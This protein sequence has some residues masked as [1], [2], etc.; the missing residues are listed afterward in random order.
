MVVLW[1]PAPLAEDHPEAESAHSLTLAAEQKC[2][3]LV[4]Q[5]ELVHQRHSRCAGMG[6]WRHGLETSSEFVIL[7]RYGMVELQETCMGA[8]CRVQ[9]LQNGSRV[10]HNI[11]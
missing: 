8:E 3:V 2:D 6:F 4:L 5:R 9:K 7:L 10:F 11:G 1:D